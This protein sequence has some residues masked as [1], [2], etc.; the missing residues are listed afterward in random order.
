ME[1]FEAETVSANRIH[2]LLLI[3]MFLDSEKI[4]RYSS[5]ELNA[6]YHECAYLTFLFL[7]DVVFKEIVIL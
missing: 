4:M 2:P 3:S 6:F 1:E 7:D 5:F